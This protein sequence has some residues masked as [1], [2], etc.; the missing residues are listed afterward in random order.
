MKGTESEYVLFGLLIVFMAC[1]FFMLPFL[2]GIVE[3]IVD[4]IGW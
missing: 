4:A 3:S 2:D 1:L